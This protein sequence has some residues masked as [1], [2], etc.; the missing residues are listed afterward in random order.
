MKRHQIDRFF[1]ILDR[2]LDQAADVILVG[3]SAGSLMGHVRPSLDIDFEIRIKGK[4]SK[5]GEV[6]RRLQ[7]AALKA[8][9]LAGVAVNYSEN[10]GGWSR[11]NYLDYRKTAVP[12]KRIG[13]LEIKLI[14]PEYWTIGKMAR[15]LDIDVNDMIKII[16]RKK[17]KPERLLLIWA[18]S[19]RSSDL[20]LEL[21]NFR[22]NVLHFLKRYGPGIWGRQFDFKKKEERF[23]KL[24][25]P[26]H[27]PP[28]KGKG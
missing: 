14:A 27:F 21:G 19:I 24:V 28:M 5:S 23:K 26:E 9:A 13:K 22:N 16:R 4:G 7:A 25:G 1:Q 15:F 10:V 12:Y 6:R 8:S 18:K 11:L 20:C 2:E 3:A 17:L